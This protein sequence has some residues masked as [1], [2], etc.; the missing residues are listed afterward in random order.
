MDRIYEAQKA[1]R[2]RRFEEIAADRQERQAKLNFDWN[3]IAGWQL[4]ANAVPLKMAELDATATANALA[5][6][7]TKV[8]VVASP[9]LST[10]PTS[11]EFTPEQRTRVVRRYLAGGESLNQIALDNKVSPQLVRQWVREVLK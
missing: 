3:R 10:Q 5:L 1:Y 4:A 7:A 2:E 8:N 9:G 11:N 6:Q